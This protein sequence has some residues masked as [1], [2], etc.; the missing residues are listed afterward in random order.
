[1]TGSRHLF[2]DI[3]CL[4]QQLG[5]GAQAQFRG[6]ESRGVN[7]LVASLL[8]VVPFG[9]RLD[10]NL[11]VLAGEIDVLRLL[12][13]GKVLRGESPFVHVETSPSGAVLAISR[14]EGGRWAN[15]GSVPTR[16]RPTLELGWLK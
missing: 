12:I 2:V 10:H 13:V 14:R 15:S 4:S 5:E 8:G 11:G 7:P 9:E 3:E 16:W 6:P 1:L